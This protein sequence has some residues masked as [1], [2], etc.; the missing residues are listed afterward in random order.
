VLL[1]FHASCF[2]TTASAL[3]LVLECGTILG[4]LSTADRS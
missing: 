1:L 3:H 2:I 4:Y